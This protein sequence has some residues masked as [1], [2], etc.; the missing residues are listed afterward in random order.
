MWWQNK[1]EYSA[2]SQEMPK[3]E[4]HHQMEEAKDDC[5][6]KAKGFRGSVAWPTP[7][8]SP[9]AFRTKTINPVALNS[10]LYVLQQAEETNITI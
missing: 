4:S 5:L 10:L 7:H 6:C 9:W 3:I 8:F 1:T 2:V